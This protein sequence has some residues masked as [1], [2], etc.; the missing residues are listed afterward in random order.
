MASTRCLIRKLRIPAWSS[1]SSM[2]VA[3]AKLSLKIYRRTVALP[4]VSAALGSAPVNPPLPWAWIAVHEGSLFSR[5]SFETW[6]QLRALGQP[7]PP[8]TCPWCDGRL[9]LTGLHLQ[10]SCI[11]FAV[12]CWTRGI[13]PESAFLYPPNDKWLQAALLVIAEVN[14][15]RQ[16]VLHSR[17]RSQP[18]PPAALPPLPE[19]W[20]DD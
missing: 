1:E 13:Q 6:W 17:H 5:A 9:P 3:A 14:E 11:T 20:V 8:D 19:N 16:T 7:Y 18:S 12:R 10:S 2:T 4:A 15:A